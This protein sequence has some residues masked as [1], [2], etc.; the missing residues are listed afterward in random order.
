[1]SKSFEDYLKVGLGLEDDSPQVA[2]SFNIDTE[3]SSSNTDMDEPLASESVEVAESIAEVA[4]ADTETEAAEDDVEELE[5]AQ[6]SLESYHVMLKGAVQNGGMSVETATSYKIGM[7]S[8]L[9]PKNFGKLD[10]VGL[11][12]FSNSRVGATVMSLENHE[13]IMERIGN[14]SMEA[15]INWLETLK[16]KVGK[17][18]NADKALLKKANGLKSL[19]ESA[20]GEKSSTK[21]I[22]AGARFKRLTTLGWSNDN[23]FLKH[24]STFAGIYSGINKNIDFEDETRSQHEQAFGGIK[25]IPFQTFGGKLNKSEDGKVTFEK[26]FNKEKSDVLVLS[27]SACGKV[28]D[29]CIRLLG[30]HTGDVEAVNGFLRNTKVAKIFSRDKEADG[31]K[32]DKSVTSV[33]NQLMSH[34]VNVLTEVLNYVQFCLTNR[35]VEEVQDG[36]S[37]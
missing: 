12:S 18:I 29:E 34:R 20:Q 37:E 35:E 10:N 32:L 14:I 31:Q 22:S 36:A 5:A 30:G 28:L 27:P 4:E 1:M 13:M 26:E 21:T 15:K 17:I 19:A 16:F 33:I 11:E 2:I 3:T 6:D 8:I 9:G 7:E 25:G 24:L 23:E